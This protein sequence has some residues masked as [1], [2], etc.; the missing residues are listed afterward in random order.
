MKKLKLMALG[1]LSVGMFTITSC[2]DDDE[3]T[4][5]FAEPNLT[6]TASSGSNIAD[7]NGD[8][9]I[10][11]GEPLKFMINGASVAGADLKSAGLTISGKNVV[12]PIPVTQKG[13]NFSSGD[14][15]LKNADEQTYQDEIEF[16]GGLLVEEG[17]TSFTFK[18]TDDNN[19][20]KTVSIRVT[21]SGAT[22][23]LGSPQT[24]QWERKGGAA[25]TGLAQF[26]LKWTSNA[27]GSAI[28]KTDAATR[29]VQLS[30]NDYASITTKEDLGATVEASAVI[31]EYTGVSTA[32]SGTYNDVLGV[33]HNGEYFILNVTKS[34]VTSST[35]GTNIIIEGL[36]KK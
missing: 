31:T 15:S 5:T 23:P 14:A 20:T 27:N 36:F 9:E 7:A 35:A 10:N 26:G 4:D 8:I 1:L 30:V 28:V 6:I 12:N 11:V 13:Y 19:K 33:R 21:T 3:G 16:V 34:T 18:V 29:F 32:A 2:A 22:T 17:V 25:G 24:F